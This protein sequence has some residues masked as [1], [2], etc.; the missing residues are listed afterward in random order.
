MMAEI[1]PREIVIFY[2]W[3]SDREGKCCK[4]FIRIA[5]D[6]A[7]DAVAAKLGVLIRID[8]DTE[9]V[10][11]HP[12]ITDTILKKIEACDLFLADMSFVA[13][14]TAG[15]LVPNPNV[16]G[17]YG[18]ALR[19]NTVERIL[20]A[21]N[22]AFGPPDGLPFDLRHM[23]HPAQ[24]ALVEGSP[25]AD[26]R[27]ARKRFTATLERN[28]EAAVRDVLAA[29]LPGI[30]D[31]WA[32]AEAVLQGLHQQPFMMPVPVIV[33]GPKLLIE[34]VPLAALEG[35]ALS[36]TRVKAARPLFPPSVM[37]KI[38]EG[39]DETHWWTSGLP[40]HVGA[41]LN[42]ETDWVF[43]LTNGGLFQI[44][45]TIGRRIDDDPDIP[46]PGQ[47]IEAHLV[48]AVDRA[49]KVAA[50]VG[51][52]GPAL[53]GASLEGLEGVEIHRSRG[54]TRRLKKNSAGLG[55]VKLEALSAPTADGLQRLM[56]QMWLVGGWDDGSHQFVDGRWTGYDHAGGRQS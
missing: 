9:G 37:A 12:A 43:R 3:Q 35:V 1:R 46:V 4:D 28:F 13:E 23:R 24:Y 16:M 40:R 6:E 7:A 38:D 11:G 50:A 19:A 2:S 51:L 31:R 25:D 52:S 39:T 5:A 33:S 36:P 17:E 10:S 55:I 27:A 18:F 15:K 54:R 26:R 48:N 56:D 44:Q 8:A 41:N 22:T 21:M 34:V 20:L 49:A 53:V 29:P 14:T 30:E 45:Q 42:P 47:E 32:E